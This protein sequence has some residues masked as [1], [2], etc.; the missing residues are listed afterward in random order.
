MAKRF[1]VESDAV[2]S[3]HTIE[4]RGALFTLDVLGEKVHSEAEANAF[5]QQYLDL[6][7]SL[8][9]KLGPLPQSGDRPAD[10]IRCGPRVNLSV[11]LS[12]L[13]AHFDPAAPERTAADV[14]RRLVP[15]LR[16]ARRHGVFINVDVE[17]F[18]VRDLT[19]RIFR[20]VAGDP[21]FADWEDIGIVVQA[22]LC[23]AA[24]HLD[25]ILAWLRSAGRARVAIRLV[26]GAYWD[27]EQIWASQ[28]NWPVPVLLNKAETDAQ[29]ERMTRTL[30]ESGSLVRTALGSHNARTV[31]RGLALA[32]GLETP[33]GDFEVQVLHGMGDTLS[34]ALIA[35]GIPVRVYV[36]WGQ[37]IPGMAYM[38]RRLLENTSNDSFLR[39]VSAARGDVAALLRDPS[40]PMQRGEAA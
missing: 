13:T 19:W 28:R 17:H 40:A 18:E 39:Q 37:L 38:V 1:I 31:A 22:Y 36:P 8:G 25:E 32:Q 9:G 2:E 10:A 35:M 33:P 5:A 15:I 30:L 11:K 16:A 12:A 7:E 6:A 14:R 26:K 24:Q 21:E 34:R 20:E 27:S 23:D 29:C 4:R 3:L